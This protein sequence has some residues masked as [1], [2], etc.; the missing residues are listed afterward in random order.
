MSLVLV[1]V[2]TIVVGKYFVVVSVHVS[3]FVTVQVSVS[4]I[5]TVEG[6]HFVAVTDVIY[7]VDGVQVDPWKLFPA[8]YSTP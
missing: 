7:T 1:F 8:T 5:V 2:E 4:L 6:Q 3:V